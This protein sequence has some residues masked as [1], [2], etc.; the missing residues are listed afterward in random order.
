[1][2]PLIFISI[3]CAFPLF[4]NVIG[5]KAQSVMDIAYFH[6]AEVA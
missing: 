5:P 3:I 1:M 2:R 4:Q 6:E